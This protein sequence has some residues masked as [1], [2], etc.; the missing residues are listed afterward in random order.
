MVLPQE[1]FHVEML[2][3]EGIQLLSVLGR[4]LVSAVILPA[5]RERVVSLETTMESALLYKRD[6][7]CLC[8]L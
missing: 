1:F 8:M 3:I 4:E 6:K 5:Q 2:F 7:N